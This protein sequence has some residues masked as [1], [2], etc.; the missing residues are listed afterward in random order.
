[1]RTQGNNL[2]EPETTS[3]VI[4]ASRIQLICLWDK[5]REQKTRL[6]AKNAGVIDE[7][8][9]F[10]GTRANDPKLNYGGED[11]FDMCLGHRGRWGRANYFSVSAS[12]CNRF[13]HINFLKTTARKYLVRR[14]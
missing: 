4:L 7:L 9:L 2:D 13:A 10:R 3:V 5:Y 14:Y 12:Q 8:N 6:H 1:M 11:G